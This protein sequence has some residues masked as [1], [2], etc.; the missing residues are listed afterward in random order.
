[1]NFRS[2]VDT[3]ID[4]NRMQSSRAEA[5]GAPL[6]QG[7]HAAGLQISGIFIEFSGVL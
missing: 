6:G 5:S 2:S 1:M 7:A 4:G 3:D